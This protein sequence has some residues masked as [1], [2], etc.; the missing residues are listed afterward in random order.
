MTNHLATIVE[1]IF[2]TAV[3]IRTYANSRLLFMVL[4]QR[5]PVAIR[6]VAIAV[7]MMFVSRR[8]NGDIILDDG[9]QH[10]IVA[11]YVD[12]NLLVAN[13]TSV[14]HQ[15][16]ITR[17][18]G[19]PG[20]PLP[21]VSVTG[22]SEFIV[23]GGEI[24]YTVGD[25]TAGVNSILAEDGS[26]VRIDSGEIFATGF[27]V[28]DSHLQVN[29]GTIAWT[30]N[31]DAWPY[32]AVVRNS[33]FTMTGGSLV[34]YMNAIFALGGGMNVYDSTVQVS[35]GT[36]EGS[37]PEGAQS[38]RLFGQSVLG[39]SGG[40]LR[41]RGND[42]YGVVLSDD[43]QLFISGGAI[44]AETYDSRSTGIKMNG[45]SELNFEGGHVQVRTIPQA[46][47]GIALTGI[48]SLGAAKVTISDGVIELG[49]EEAAKLLVLNAALVHAKET[50]A[51]E[52]VGGTFE[53][54]GFDSRSRIL[55]DATGAA[56]IRVSGGDFLVDG[57]FLGLHATQ[58][59]EIVVAGSEFNYPMFEAIQDLDGVIAGKLADGTAI[60]WS[61]SRDATANIILV[62]EPSSLAG[63]FILMLLGRRSLRR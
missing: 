11:A 52:V 55:F 26:T 14:I 22:A 53:M 15:G 48:E 63:V 61:F 58:Q 45:N 29:G 28:T 5:S 57:P 27:S 1:F 30:Y 35:G 17:A 33:D 19:V 38:I 47:L 18:T 41:G 54:N 39:L 9:A 32:G 59:A 21:M 20:S 31:A 37:A 2:R 23:D 51:I 13:Q 3:S 24:V 25:D 7:V 10:T 43:S 44:T 40:E 46:T 8:T 34:G 60:E 42:A 50:S 56:T 49:S 6:L 36:I 12:E 4:R 16:S 62:P